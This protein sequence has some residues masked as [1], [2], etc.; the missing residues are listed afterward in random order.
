MVVEKSAY[1]R[2]Q[3]SPRGCAIQRHNTHGM[4]ILRYDHKGMI[5]YAAL[6]Q[7]ALNIFFT[8]DTES[9]V[10]AAQTRLP[11]MKIEEIRKLWCAPLLYNVSR[12]PVSFLRACHTPYHTPPEYQTHRLQML[13]SDGDV[14]DASAVVYLQLYIIETR[15]SARSDPE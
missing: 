12:R 8:C 5:G 13:M 7:L 2:Y 3:T 4:S 9:L 14:L 10:R 1:I 15:N 6:K 11:G